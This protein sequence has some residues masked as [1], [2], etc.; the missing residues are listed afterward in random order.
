MKHYLIA[1]SA[2]VFFSFQAIS[3]KSEGKVVYGIDVKGNAA[4][5]EEQQVKTLM[6]TSKLKLFFKGKRSRS[7]FNMAGMMNII[8]INGGSSE[9]TLLMNGMIG[10]IA[11]TVDAKEQA[12]KDEVVNVELVDGN[13]EI[14][15]FNCKKALVTTESGSKVTFWYTDKIVPQATQSQYLSKKMPGLPMEFEVNKDGVKVVFKAEKFEEKIENEK[16]VF[17]MTIPEGYEVKTAEE[18]QRIG[19]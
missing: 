19:G 16:T 8:A 7:E 14:L 11:S 3:Q 9:T 18:L 12:G 15:G 1:F 10:K 13:K 4:T 5:P 2:L 6:S 17:D